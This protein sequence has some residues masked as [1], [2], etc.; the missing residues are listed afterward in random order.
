MSQQPTS[1][2]ENF[3]LKSLLDPYINTNAYYNGFININSVEPSLGLPSSNTY[4]APDTVYYFPVIT[5]DEIYG[6]SRK[7]TNYSDTLT[8]NNNNVGIGTALPTSKLTVFGDISATYGRLY[9]DDLPY[10]MVFS[11]SSIKATQGDNEIYDSFLGQPLYSNIN[12]G[13]YNKMYGTYSSIVGGYLNEVDS[14]LSFIG[15]GCNNIING[16]C[17]AIVSGYCNSILNNSEGAFIGSGGRNTII[18]DEGSY[19]GIPYPDYDEITNDESFSFIGAGSDNFISGIHSAILAGRQNSL[20]GSNSFILGSK[21]STDVHNTTFVNNLSSEGQLRGTLLYSPSAHFGDSVIDHNLTVYGNLSTLGT[22]VDINTS[23]INTSSLR[24]VNPGVGPTIYAQQVNGNYDIANFVSQYDVSV[25]NIKNAP[26]EGLGKVGINTNSPNTEL[27]V[28]GDISASRYIYGHFQGTIDS[29]ILTDLTA[30]N[31]TAENLYSTNGIFNNLTVN[32]VLSAS[33]IEGYGNEV[34]IS[35]GLSANDIGNGANTLSLNFDNGVFVSQDLIVGG[36]IYGDISNATG[37][38]SATSVYTSGTGVDSIKPVAGN[39]TASGYS[40][41]VAGGLCNTAS[42]NCSTVSGGLYNTSCGDTSVIGGGNGNNASGSTSTIS[43]GYYNCSCLAAYNSTISG[44]YQNTVNGNSASVGG[45]CQNN[46]SGLASTI[47]GGYNNT[48]SGCYS[49]VAGGKCNIASGYCS[50]I[51]GG[52]GNVVTHNNSFAIG[53]DLTSDA[54]NTTYVNNL[55]IM[56][57]PSTF[58]NPVTASGY[59]LIV[60]INGTNKAIQLWDYTS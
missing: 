49:N 8:I 29:Q 16:E 2:G 33:L 40:S 25:L 54:D 15:G 36:A 10:T 37:F 7:F 46:S 4:T 12:G 3:K 26:F 47:S 5:V 55:A 14:S 50:S 21:I 59:F 35:D 32:D 48:A 19:N 42:G 38:P 45:G 30:T 18:C 43:G 11:N 17:S 56:Q 27:T 20:S 60:N 23:V 9:A 22:R 51:L 28:I 41:N 13:R 39:N 44:G 1:V 31:I 6:N 34:V 53:S 58:N 24:L 52:C 57:T